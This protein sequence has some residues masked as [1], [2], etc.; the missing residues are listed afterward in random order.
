LLIAS[1]SYLNK[2]LDLGARSCILF[3]E[4][5]GQEKLCQAGQGLEL[6]PKI[7]KA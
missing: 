7:T 5:C 6:N 1:I 4:D 2:K 3:Q